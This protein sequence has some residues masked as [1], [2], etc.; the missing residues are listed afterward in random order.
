MQNLVCDQ[1]Y[2]IFGIYR[3]KRQ[4]LFA[5][6]KCVF[7]SVSKRHILQVLGLKL[8]TAKARRLSTAQVQCKIPNNTTRNLLLLWNMFI[9]LKLQQCYS[10]VFKHTRS[11]NAA[12]QLLWVKAIKPWPMTTRCQHAMLCPPATS[13][14]RHS[15][16]PLIWLFPS[17]AGFASSPSVFLFNSFSKRTFGN[18]WHRFSWAG[19]SSCHPNNS[20]EA[21][22]KQRPRPERIIHSSQPFFTYCKTSLCCIIT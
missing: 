21:N 19:S 5:N 10:I 9:W 16:A 18:I 15:L 1:K 20:V 13:K 7:C 17:E 22:A 14:T 12:T 4:I 8:V 2:K 6:L 3:S 11:Y